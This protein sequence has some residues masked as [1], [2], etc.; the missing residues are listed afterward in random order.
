MRHRLPLRQGFGV[1]NTFQATGDVLLDRN[2]IGS[3][4]LISGFNVDTDRLLFPKYEEDNE[5]YLVIEVAIR[6]LKI[7]P[8]NMSLIGM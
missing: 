4:T 3:D 7:G 6:V 5:V 8:W 1:K 2:Q